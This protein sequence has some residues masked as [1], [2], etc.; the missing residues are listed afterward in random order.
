MN[1]SSKPQDLGSV[2]LY[3]GKPMKYRYILWH[4]FF[5]FAVGFM[6]TGCNVARPMVGLRAEYPE[7]RGS[8]VTVESFQPTLRWEPFSQ[9]VARRSID[10]ASLSQMSEVSYDLRI[11]R[12]EIKSSAWFHAKK[13]YPAEL[14]YEKKGISTPHHQVEIPLALATDYMWT[15]RALFQLGSEDRVTQWGRVGRHIAPRSNSVPNPLYYRFA[16]PSMEKDQLL[17]R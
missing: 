2:G 15:V 17:P 11:W 4:S 8:F 6:L 13:Y 14:V 1:S 5:V 12:A 10:K 16:T 9:F 3:Y 7:A